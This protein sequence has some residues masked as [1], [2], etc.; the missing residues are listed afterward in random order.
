V[1]VASLDTRARWFR[2]GVFLA[3][4]TVLSFFTM[5]QLLLAYWGKGVN[6]SIHE[7]FL[8]G[9][10]TW[11][12]WA[13]FAPMIDALWRQFPFEGPGLRRSVLVH[14]SVTPV[15]GLAWTLFRWT[16]SFIPMI[17][18]MPIDFTWTLAAH[19][20]LWFLSYWVIV[21][22]RQAS[23]N[24]GRFREREVRASV[25]EAKLA[26]AQLEMLKMQLHPHFLFNTLHGISTLI[27]SDAPAAKAM[28]VKLS[29]LLR[30]AV[31]HDSADLVTLR[32]ELEFAEAYLDLEKMRLGRRLQCRM[33]VGEHTSF[34]FVPQLIL[35][36]LIEN[37]IVHGVACCR[38]GGWLEIGSRK[39]GGWLELYVRNSVGGR[40][41]PGTGLGLANTK[42]RLKHL[43]GGTAALEFSLRE[44]VFAEVVV[45]MPAFSS[46]FAPRR[47]QQAV[48]D[49]AVGGP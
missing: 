31:K 12:P 6:L 39:A 11:Y 33:N 30:I 13:L 16:A 14:L 38:E 17:D 2:W 26:Q 29:S 35:Q 44:N 36:P 49:V 20:P 48:S 9:L 3:G 24:Y 46:S 21:T 27:D 8:S 10:A 34:L 41:E 5:V 25:L 40:S 7:A 4:L 28:I 45:R 1:P 15:F 37:A 42:A 32:D 43:Y 22:V 23:Y 47:E 18:P 19:F